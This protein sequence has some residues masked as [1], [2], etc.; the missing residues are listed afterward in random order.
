VRLS[1][2]R[3]RRAFLTLPAVFSFLVVSAYVVAEV[4]GA[5][6]LGHSR[7]RYQREVAQLR[8][9][10]GRYQ[11][12]VVVGEPLQQNAASWYRL[13]LP[14]LSG[15]RDDGGPHCRHGRDIIAGHAGGA[16]SN[17]RRWCSL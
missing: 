4:W 16:F 6:Y 11:R 1:P 5:R 13:A 8:E 17:A 9:Q 12:P 7:E 3:S 2:F 15:W 14:H 10:R